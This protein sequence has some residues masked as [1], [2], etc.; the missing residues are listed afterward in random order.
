MEQDTSGVTVTLADGSRVGAELLIGVDGVH[1]VTR[2]AVLGD[3]E[4]DYSGIVAYRGV[5]ELKAPERIGERHPLFDRRPGPA[6]THRRVTLLGDAAHPV[7]PFLGQ[8][9]CQA[10]E[11]AVA[12][13]DALDAEGLV[14]AALPRYETAR[15]GRVAMDRE[16]VADVGATRAPARRVAAVAARWPDASGAGRGGASSARH[17]HRRRRRL[18]PTGP[19]RFSTAPATRPVAGIPATYGDDLPSRTMAPG[20]RPRVF[21]PVAPMAHGGGVTL[22]LISVEVWPDGVVAHAVGEL[23]PATGQVEVAAEFTEPWI[24]WEQNMREGTG[25]PRP[26]PDSA[27]ALL[28]GA[29]HTTLGL[30]DDAGTHYRHHASQS[31]GTGTEWRASWHFS[32]GIPDTATVLSVAL[33]GDHL[34]STPVTLP[35]R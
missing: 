8:G 29:A 30:S 2:A 13:G 14:P 3:G 18:R 31:G 12:L 25:P 34:R 19:N 20:G 17:R 10:I 21:A 9:A 11:D 1:S 5:V 7:L 24:R 32:P 4:P 23:D 26:A 27:M 33:T 6:W 16:P 28:F 15:R 35:L 22:L